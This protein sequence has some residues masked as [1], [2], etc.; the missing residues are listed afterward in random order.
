MTDIFVLLDIVEKF[1]FLKPIGWLYDLFLSRC[2]GWCDRVLVDSELYHLIE[3]VLKWC[4][5]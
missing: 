4:I 3:K 5:V 1:K 2:P